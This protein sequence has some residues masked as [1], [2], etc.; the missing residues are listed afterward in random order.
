MVLFVLR[1]GET[2]VIGNTSETAMFRED[3]YIIGCPESSMF[4]MPFIGNGK[5]IG[6]LYLENTKTTGA[7]TQERVEFLKLLS[8]HMA[9]SI[10]NARLYADLQE[11]K[12]QLS[13]WNKILEQTVAT[14]TKELK[15]ANEQLSKAIDAAEKANCAKSEFLAMV[16]HEI[17]TPLNGIIGMTE[18]LEKT[19]TEKEQFEYSS[20]IQASSELLLTIINDILDFTKIEEGKLELESKSFRMSSIEKTIL[21]AIEPEARRRGI[22]LHSYFEPEIPALIGDPLRLSQ[23]LLNLIS[24]AVKFT[25]RGEIKI[26]V[27]ITKQ[28]SNQTFV[29]FEVQDTGIGIPKHKQ[30]FIFQP[31]Y[32]ADQSTNRHYGGTGLGLAICKRLVELMQGEIGFRSVEG[33]GS[34]FWFVVPFLKWSESVIFD[35]DP[36]SNSNLTAFEKKDK[37]G[38][39]L[40]VEDNAINQKLFLSQLEKCGLTAVIAANGR[41]AVK[42]YSRNRFALIF[43]DCQMP[44]MDGYETAKVI[45]NMESSSD[46]HTPIIATTAG[47]MPGERERCLESGM[48]DFIIKPIRM[49]DLQEILARWL[50]DISV[51]HQNRIKYKD[52]VKNN[53]VS[54]FASKFVDERDRKDFLE[55]V[56]KDGVFLVDVLETFLQEM[57]EKIK[58]LHSSFQQRDLSNLRLVAHGMKTDGYLLKFN[59]LADICKKLEEAAVSGRLDTAKK[60]ITQISKEYNHL[61]KQITI[62]LKEQRQL[63]IN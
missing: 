50:P 5:N 63:Q 47:L 11:S 59:G 3:P 32:Q 29:R 13:N 52:F 33:K 43:M 58:R 21:A 57:P 28:E 22:T 14:R 19:L 31:F 55:M 4:C 48:D 38:L 20:A 26:R 35:S 12:D 9:I 41:D 25:H 49:R 24:N 18:L 16:S 46:L 6:I 51:S 45:R 10:E 53:M 37:S 23:V 34:T 2:V 60:F 40:V 8:S 1:T 61:E 44:D 36:S 27:F 42:A 39:V 30:K 62:F 54:N 17:R 15:A 7:F 56:G